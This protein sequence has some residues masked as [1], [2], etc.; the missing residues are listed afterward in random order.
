MLTF[1]VV[2]HVCFDSS[3]NNNSIISGTIPH[4]QTCPWMLWL[5]DNKAISGLYKLVVFCICCYLLSLCAGTIPETDYNRTGSIRIGENRVSGSICPS[6]LLGGFLIDLDLSSNHRISGTVPANISSIGLLF[7]FQAN[8]LSGTLS[9]GLLGVRNIDL[10]IQA[11]LAV[12]A[13]QSR[14]SRA[15]AASVLNIG[16]N[17]ISGTLPNNK[18]ATLFLQVEFKCVAEKLLCR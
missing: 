9:S 1:V 11:F 4:F 5:Q 8:R 14:Y 13:W 16:G 12:F 2:S 3:L 17:S 7:S 18:N 6:V 15:N 10:T